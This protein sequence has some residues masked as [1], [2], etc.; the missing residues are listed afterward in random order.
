MEKS[1]WIYKIQFKNNNY[2]LPSLLSVFSFTSVNYS[3]FNHLFNTHAITNKYILPLDDNGFY[4]SSCTLR[5]LREFIKYNPKLFS[6]LSSES[7]K[8]RITRFKNKINSHNG[9]IN[10]LMQTFDKLINYLEAM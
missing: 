7:I 3:L 4:Y 8:K 9:V 6:S 2:F 5:D 1:K 10:N